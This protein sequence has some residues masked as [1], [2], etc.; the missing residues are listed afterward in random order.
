MLLINNECWVPHPWRAFVFA[1][2]VG[3][4]EPQPA[5]P[6]QPQ[7]VG[8]PGLEFET[9]ESTNPNQ[10]LTDNDYTAPT[11]SPRKKR[12]S[13]A[14]IQGKTPEF[15]DITFNLGYE[16][17]NIAPDFRPFF[18]PFSALFAQIRAVLAYFGLHRVQAHNPTH[19]PSFHS[20]EGR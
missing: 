17:V 10:P 2:R 8:A 3:K 15:N 1:P 18:S 14:I 16:T 12:L 4:H 20:L 6:N 19:L 7:I 9:W 13:A 11:P 5:I